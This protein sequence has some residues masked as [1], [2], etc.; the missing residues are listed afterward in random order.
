MSSP[1]PRR[2]GA[3]AAG[4]RAIRSGA[5][6]LLTIAALVTGAAIAVPVRAEDG[7]AT[8]PLPQGVDAAGRA[9]QPDG[10]VAP[11]ADGGPSITRNEIISRAKSWADVPVPYSQTAYRDGYRTD[12]SGYVS[13]AWKL[14]RNY[15]TGDLNTVGVAIGYNDLQPGDM[16]LYHNAANPVNGSHVVLFDRWTGAVGGDFIIYEQTVPATKHRAWSQAG[17]SRSLYKPYRYANVVAGSPPVDDIGVSA[18]MDGTL[19]RVFARGTDGA[20]WQYVW[21]G[22]TWSWGLVGGKITGAPSAVIWG[23]MLR[24]FARGADGAVWQYMWNGSAWS[25]QEIGGRIIGGP[26]AVVYNGELKVF[27]RGTDN[28]LWQ[29]NWNGSAWSWQDRGGV[30][31]SAPSAVVH[32][33]ILRVFARAADGALWQDYWNGTSWT[34]QKIGGA[35]SSG[36]AGVV[37]GDLKVFAEGND[38][39]LWQD[40]WNGTSWGWQDRGGVITSAPSAVVHGSILRV[41]ARGNDGALWQDYWNGTSWTWQKIG[42]AIT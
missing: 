25:W 29:D 17:Y 12:C 20:L 32:G 23:G 11:Y 42:G 16:L 36:P 27:A 5:I 8:V 22:S 41:F 39:A 7:S 2:A 33:G 9:R 21:N 14:Y 19:L 15:W 38:H 35:I 40:N 37:Y 28:G 24:V 6:I 30:I 18:I 3:G 13:M 31:T 26:A 4:R 10:T 34:W 1:I